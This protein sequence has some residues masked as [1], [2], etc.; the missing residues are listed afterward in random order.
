MRAAGAVLILC[1]AIWGYL[2]FRRERMLTIALYR[3]LASDLAVLK[4][5][6]C[7]RR[8]TLPAILSQ[9]LTQGVGAA[10]LWIPFQTLLAQNQ[11]SVQ[12]GWHTV[13]QALPGQFRV[14]LAP[15]GALL[16]GGGAPLGQCLDEVREALLRDLHGEE[17]HY[18]DSLR[19]AGAICLSGACFLILILL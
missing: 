1:G 10:Y 11:C 9:E 13:L 17:R 12:E 4:S 8:R 16:A 5:E 14:H 19:L 18:A 7:I 6:V 3:A 15:L 2:Q